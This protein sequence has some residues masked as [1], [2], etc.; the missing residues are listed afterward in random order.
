MQV[1]N[2][3]N[4]FSTFEAQAIVGAAAIS[5]REASAALLV[6]DLPEIDTGADT[7]PISVSG[8]ITTMR[9]G[10]LYTVKVGRFR[11]VRVSNVR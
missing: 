8:K 6:A 5:S 9:K 1:F 3:A 2:D 10:E 4:R 11:L 7:G